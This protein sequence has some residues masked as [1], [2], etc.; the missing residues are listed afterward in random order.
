VHV[1]TGMLLLTGVAPRAVALVEAMMMTSF[2][3]LLH[4]PRVLAAPHDRAEL[5]MLAIATTLAGAIFAA[6]RAPISNRR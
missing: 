6:T 5:T 1:G 3:L 2:V 4:V